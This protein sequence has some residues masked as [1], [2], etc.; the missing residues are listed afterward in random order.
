MIREILEN[1]PGIFLM[2]FNEKKAARERFVRGDIR[3]KINSIPQMVLLT[4]KYN[5]PVINL[6]RGM[7]DFGASAL[8]GE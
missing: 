1:V 6:C 7:L 8:R 3:S 5:Y 4:F 2:P